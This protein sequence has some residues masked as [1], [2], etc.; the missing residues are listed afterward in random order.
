[1]ALPKIGDGEQIGDGNANEVL[2][3]GG[4]GQTVRV[5]QTGATLQFK[6]VTAAANVTAVLTT[7]AATGLVAY[8]STAQLQAHV[9]ATNSILTALK[10]AGIMASS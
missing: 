2:I 8:A 6:G 1:M 5:G 7:G 10:N 9:D 3:V 4:V